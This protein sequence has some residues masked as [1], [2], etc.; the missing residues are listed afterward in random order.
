MVM[1]TYKY[2]RGYITAGGEI[3]H[4]VQT[5]H[6]EVTG[7]RGTNGGRIKRVLDPVLVADVVKRREDSQTFA[8]IKRDL[9]I[10]RWIVNRI[11]RENQ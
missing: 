4:T 8:Q 2:T 6:R 10:S 9:G 5:V 7:V 3:K 1:K 11:V